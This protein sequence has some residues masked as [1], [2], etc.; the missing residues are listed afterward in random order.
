MF[1]Y[2]AYVHILKNEISKLDGKAKKCIFLGYGHEESRYKLWDLVVKKLIRSRDV[3]FIK[4]QIDGN[5]KKNDE[6]Q[7]SLKIP[8]IPT[9][10]SLPIVHDDYGEV[11]S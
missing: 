8:I 9:S 7:S 6:S 4:D 3:V 2:R 1:G 11:E 10:V 5:I